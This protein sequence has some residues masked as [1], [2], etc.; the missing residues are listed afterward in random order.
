MQKAKAIKKRGGSWYLTQMASAKSYEPVKLLVGNE[1]ENKGQNTY[2]REVI[3]VLL[4]E[5]E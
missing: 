5:K 4:W 3:T 2:E 1:S